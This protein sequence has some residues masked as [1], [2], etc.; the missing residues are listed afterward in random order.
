[1]HGE[2]VVAPTVGRRF[3]STDWV[4][5]R[6]SGRMLLHKAAAGLRPDVL[7][8][9][10]G[11]VRFP[12]TAR[13][14]YT[15]DAAAVVDLA[16]LTGAGIIAPVHI[17]VWSYFAQRSGPQPGHSR[18]RGSPTTSDGCRSAKLSR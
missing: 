10:V 16:E 17:D 6:T 1:M 9:H 11:A 3:R 13:I 2:F 15:M 5:E 12:Q 14:T 8:A 4:G 7:L 18:P